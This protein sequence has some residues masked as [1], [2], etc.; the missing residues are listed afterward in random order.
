MTEILTESFCERCGTRYTFESAAPR[1]RRIGG[2]K[3]LGRG[4]KNFV[5]SDEPLDEAIA[6]A[7]SDSDREASAQQLD[8]FHRT[9]NFCMSCRQY[10][11]ANCWNEPEAR[12]LSCAPLA[13]PEEA[14]FFQADVDPDR[15]LRFVGGPAAETPEPV[16]ASPVEA[17]PDPSAPHA[18]GFD[19]DTPLVQGDES[20]VPDLLALGG[21]VPGQSL[22]DALAAYEA[23]RVSEDA[24][25][26]EDAAV[27]APEPVAESP[28]EASTSDLRTA[29]PIE[30]A[31]EPIA[32]MPVEPGPEPI[33]PATPGVDIVE[34]PVWPTAAAPAPG[35]PSTT[36]GAPATPAPGGEEAHQPPAGPPQWPIGPR[37]PTSMPSR[38]AAPS[39]SPAVDPLAS[40]IARTSTE[41]MWA[42]SSR[43]ILQPVKT[44]PPA[45]RPCTSC[46]I[47][48]SASARF[49]RRCGVQQ[50]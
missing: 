19:E 41:A 6:S 33:R 31:P 32:A 45:V 21:L 40:L 20:H 46:G 8:A 44:Q 9:F 14:R 36:P 7:R 18:A 11:C 29:A 49:C 50:G 15:L 42:A 16:A 39:P 17:E 34:Q 3:V 28:T 2:L 5:L 22:D 37:W 26:P 43:E 12:C 38:G 23:S 48:L 35:V 27:A 25:R 13:V 4:L 10:T 1:Q 47:S 24:P 30:P